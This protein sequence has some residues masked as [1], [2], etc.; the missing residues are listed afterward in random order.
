MAPQGGPAGTREPQAERGAGL[1]VRQPLP[2]PPRGAADLLRRRV[3]CLR[4]RRRARRPDR[5]RREHRRR[6]HPRPGAPQQREHGHAARRPAAADADVPVRE[7]GHRRA[8]PRRQRRRR[9]GG[10]LPRVHPRA[11]EPPDHGRDRR[12]RA[13]PRAVRRRWARRGATGTPRTSSSRSNPGID[14]AADGEI[15]MGAYVD[16]RPTRSARQPIDCSVGSTARRCPGGVATGPAATPTATSASLARRAPEPPTSPARSGARRSGTSASCS[17]RSVAEAIIT[18]GD[19]PLAAA[20]LVPRRAQR[21]PA[22][23][24]GAATAGSTSTRS[25]AC[26]RTAAWGSPPRPR[27]RMTRRPHADFTLPPARAAIDRPGHR[28]RRPRRRRDAAGGARERRGGRAGPVA[29][30]GADRTPRPPAV[31]R[32]SRS[33]A[34]RPAARPRR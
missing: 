31:A 23:R 5:R 29:P 2:R 3:R 16:T 34:R 22:G 21:D 10:R 7:P 32:A 1:L 13:E 9:R 25:G 17:A 18:D 8:V 6:R 15:D 24:H 12:G 14:T 33:A 20:A 19:A 27:A 30:D 26:S 11:V 4:R 28:R